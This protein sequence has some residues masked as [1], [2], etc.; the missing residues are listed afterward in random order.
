MK[1]R[2]AGSN[3]SCGA[4]SLLK[5][6]QQHI[7]CFLLGLQPLRSCFQAIIRQGKSLARWYYQVTYFFLGTSRC[8]CTIVLSG[9]CPLLAITSCTVPSRWRGPG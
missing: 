6:H 7:R 4:A 1:L 8:S 5:H 2:I 3:V 9:S